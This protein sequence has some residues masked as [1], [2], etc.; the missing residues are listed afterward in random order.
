MH[1]SINEK[2]KIMKTRFSRSKTYLDK[3]GNKYSYEMKYRGYWQFYKFTDKG[4]L[5][6][7]YNEESLL[8]LELTE[9][10]N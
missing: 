7:T 10:N 4:T 6:L 2:N 9:K 1:I 5:F 8:K 3:D